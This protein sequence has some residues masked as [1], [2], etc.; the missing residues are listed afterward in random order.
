M[1]VQ[2]SDS[3]E[4]VFS[5]VQVEKLPTTMLF[6]VTGE[7]HVRSPLIVSLDRFSLIGPARGRGVTIVL[8][9][10]PEAKSE[11]RSNAVL[12]FNACNDLVVRNIRFRVSMESGQTYGQTPAIRVRIRI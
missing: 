7:L 1:W 3:L 10:K 9:P 11:D 6:N 5:R 2:E 8:H 12:R 4:V